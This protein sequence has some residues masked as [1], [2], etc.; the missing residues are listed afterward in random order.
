MTVQIMRDFGVGDGQ[1]FIGGRWVDAAG[2]DRRTVAN[3][4]DGSTVAAVAEGTTEDVDRAVAAARKAQPAWQA[5]TVVERAALLN[6]LAG[7]IEDNKETLAGLLTSE[8]GKTLPESRIDA[9]FAALLLRYAAESGRHIQGEI[10][11]GENRDEQIWIQR[12]PYG[13]VAGITAWNFPAA[14]FARKVGPALVAGNTVVI[15]PHEFTPLTTLVLGELCRRA[16]IPDGVVNVVVGDGRTVGAHLVAH[17]G[18]DL[19]SMTGSVRAGGRSTRSAPSASSRSAWSSA[20]RH[21]SSSWTTPT[22]TRPWTQ[23]W[24]RSSSRVGRSAPATTACTCTGRST[25][26]SWRS[27]WRR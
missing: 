23:R 6:R 15:K 25:M 21:P 19:I 8:G 1:L 9:G 17:E 12:V 2:K 4:K 5:T 22:S 24:R 27:S 26:P 3:P 11:P 7:L 18:T 13:V 14:L 16:G 20:A 10:M